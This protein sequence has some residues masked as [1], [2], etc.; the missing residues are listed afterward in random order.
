M[1]VVERRCRSADIGGK[2]GVNMRET[3]NKSYKPQNQHTEL[4][5]AN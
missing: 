4:I 5:T 2:A 1:F 3:Q